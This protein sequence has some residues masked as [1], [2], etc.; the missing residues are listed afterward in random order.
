MNAIA[1]LVDADNPTL[2]RLLE[3]LS[4][5]GAVAILGELV[6]ETVRSNLSG[7]AQEMLMLWIRGVSTLYPL[8]LQEA[9]RKKIMV[10]QARFDAIK[11]MLDK[12]LMSSP[13]SC[14]KSG[15]PVLILCADLLRSKLLHLCYEWPLGKDNTAL[16]N[17]LRI[18][19]RCVPNSIEGSK[20]FVDG[21]RANWK[22]VEPERA[23]C[24]MAVL[25]EGDSHFVGYKMDLSRFLLAGI[26]RNQSSPTRNYQLARVIHPLIQSDPAV[27]EFVVAEAKKWGKLAHDAQALQKRLQSLRV[28]LANVACVCRP[29]GSITVTGQLV[30]RGDIGP[31]IPPVQLDQMRQEKLVHAELA[32]QNWRLE[33]DCQAPVHCGFNDATRLVDDGSLTKVTYPPIRESV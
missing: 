21:I 25:Q 30:Y 8:S 7:P 11:G 9:D 19:L 3:P 28:H 15:P 20:P 16:E 33:T 24:F 18:L 27:I 10:C 26:P 1:P 31:G 29:D 22:D 12:L 32:I 4:D 13:P 2:R 23:I 5:V 17:S 6:Q 14:G